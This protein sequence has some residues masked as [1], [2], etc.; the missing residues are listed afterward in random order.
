MEFGRGLTTESVEFLSRRISG[1][2]RRLREGGSPE[3]IRI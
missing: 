2:Y 3:A 1:S